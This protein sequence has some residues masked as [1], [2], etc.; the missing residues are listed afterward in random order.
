MRQV[1]MLG[2]IHGVGKSHLCKKILDLHICDV[3]SASNLM[4]DY[5]GEKVDDNKQ[6]ENINHNQNILLNAIEEYV[7]I[8]RLILLDGHFCLVNQQKGI[9]EIPRDTFRKLSIKAIV[10]LIDDENSIID[11]I[12]ERDG[13]KYSFD[14]IE[15]FQ[16]KEVEYAIKIA[17]ELKVKFLLY[18]IND[19][20]QKI[21]NLIKSIG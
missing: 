13:V 5:I 8:D 18:K 19:D 14:Y 20:I 16:R 6:V 17:E 21:L 15:Y 4:R 12:F 9:T 7:K 3:Y 10:V 11:R 2:G 1:I